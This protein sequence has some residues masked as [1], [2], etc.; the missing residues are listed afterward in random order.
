MDMAFF[1]PLFA[2]AFPMSES[3]VTLH[4]LHPVEFPDGITLTMRMFE[5]HRIGLCR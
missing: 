5:G 3:K 4:H 1:L 2:V